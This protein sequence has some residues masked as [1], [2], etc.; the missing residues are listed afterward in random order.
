MILRIWDNVVL[1]RCERLL[2][3]LSDSIDHSLLCQFVQFFHRKL[4]SA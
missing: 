3:W 4:I 2:Q 1:L